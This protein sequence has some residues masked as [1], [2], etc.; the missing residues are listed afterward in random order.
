MKRTP[1]RKIHSPQPLQ[2][3]LHLLVPPLL[4]RSRPD[5]LQIIPSL[6]IRTIL[7][8]NST[9]TEKP[10]KYS[11]QTPPVLERWFDVPRLRDPEVGRV[12]IGGRI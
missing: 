6:S 1:T 12:Q 9:I 10:H 8:R 4:L 2:N 7:C 3:N 5:R 11:F